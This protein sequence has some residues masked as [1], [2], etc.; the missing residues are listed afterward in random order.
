M[1]RN[2]VIVRA[3][4]RS[5]HP[6]WLDDPGRNWDLAVSYYGDHPDRYRDQFDLLHMSKGS[7]WQGIVR[8]LEDHPG[9]IQNY[10]YVWLPDDDILTGGTNISLFFRICEL[11]RFTIAQP[12][13]T[14]YSFHSWPITLQEHGVLARTT[15]FVEIMA[16]CFRVEHFAVFSDTFGEN[17]SGWGYEWLWTRLAEDHGIS[18]LGIVDRTPV[19]HT[20][21]VGS[22]GHGG[23]STNPSEEY[24]LLMERFGL[25]KQEP[26]VFKRFAVGA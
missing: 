25:S 15:N 19:H 13:L 3:G 8:F 10:R 21:P 2:L 22:A 20:R 18:N 11:L 14:S 1:R 12:A 9:L 23:S 26:E 17:T 7:K 5:L 6:Q 4:D 24:R 16:P